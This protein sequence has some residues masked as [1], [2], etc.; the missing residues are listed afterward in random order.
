MISWGVKVNE[1]GNA[2]LD[3]QG[4]FVKLPGQGVTEELWD[5]MMAYAAANNLKGG[6]VKKLNLPFENRILGQPAEVRERMAQAVEDF[7]FKLLT[8]VFNA[9][10]TAG[11]TI[12]LL[13]DAGSWDLGPKADRI[14]D[15]N[16]WT[17]EA[18]RARAEELARERGPAGDYED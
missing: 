4:A 15:P 14:E 17:E 18:I 13:T 12:G 9:Q 8:E 2:E 6:N 3:A 7:V 10:G 5:E 11:E 16:Q 1:F